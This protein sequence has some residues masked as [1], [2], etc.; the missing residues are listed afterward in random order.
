MTLRKILLLA[1]VEFQLGTTVYFKSIT[2][3]KIFHVSGFKN[4]FKGDPLD[5]TVDMNVGQHCHQDYRFSA[6]DIAQEYEFCEAPK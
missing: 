1:T 3:G 4:K 6:Y 2:S 5:Y